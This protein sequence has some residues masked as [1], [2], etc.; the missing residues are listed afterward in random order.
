MPEL[1][2]QLRDLGLRAGATV[3][4]HASMRAV[5]GRAEALLDALED[6]VTADGRIL[7]LLCGPE[8]EPLDPA[9]SPAWDELGVL[10]EVFR[11]RATA[12]NDHP[13]ARFGA[14]GRDAESLVIDPPLHDYYGPGSPLE[15]L[16]EADGHV[17]R[18]GADE[19]T[20]TLFHHAEY[21]A[22]VPDK[23][24]AV[25]TWERLGPDGVEAITVRRL[26][27]DDGIRPFDGEDYFKLILRELL[28]AGLASVGPV[29]GAR[30]ELL[31]AR[32]SVDFAVRWLERTFGASGA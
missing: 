26:D 20:V 5:G 12:V 27:D 15:R 28:A 30:A 24:I 2:T 11:R 1:S 10:P 3:M 9:T 29:G 6:V 21:V 18:L 19:D 25:G 8:D 4:V 16:V 32:E 7:M 17:L 13:V 22:D 23:R 14:W 31:P